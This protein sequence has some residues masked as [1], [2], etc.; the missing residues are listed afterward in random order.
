MLAPQFEVERQMA[1]PYAILRAQTTLFEALLFQLIEKGLF[2]VEDCERVF[3][4]AEKKTD[5]PPAASDVK[6]VIQHTRDRM[7]W[8][9][10]HRLRAARGADK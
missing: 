3:D 6:A 9:A 4:I 1:E 10:M 2:T 7:P 8:D 5:M